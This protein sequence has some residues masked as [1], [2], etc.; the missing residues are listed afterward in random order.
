MVCERE[1]WEIS[2]QHL[3][4]VKRWP[5]G[6]DMWSNA[7]LRLYHLLGLQIVCLGVLW[8]LRNVDT[9]Y[10]FN[11]KIKKYLRD[12]LLHT[13]N[14]ITNLMSSYGLPPLMP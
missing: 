11:I 8:I 12:T 9:K 5:D 6:I 3:L 1:D 7:V 14:K 13:Q 4:S 2:L 10:R